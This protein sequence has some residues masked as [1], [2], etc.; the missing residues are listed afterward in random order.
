[1]ILAAPDR[2]EL[3]TGL[4][5]RPMLHREDN[6]MM[7]HAGLSPSWSADDAQQLASELESASNT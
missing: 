5:Q 6:W 1:M 4:R 3:L 7:L 2:D